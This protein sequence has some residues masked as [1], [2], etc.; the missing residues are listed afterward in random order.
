MNKTCFEG[1]ASLTLVV[2]GIRIRLMTMPSK[3][4]YFYTP[5]IFKRFALR[6]V[7]HFKKYRKAYLFRALT[8]GGP[9]QL[10]TKRSEH[11]N[12]MSHLQRLVKTDCPTNL[13]NSAANKPS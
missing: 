3:W 5:Q 2:A 1:S 7:C 11:N 4:A 9:L 8:P 6:L 12:L 13:A 10:L